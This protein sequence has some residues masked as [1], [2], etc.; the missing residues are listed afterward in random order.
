MQ[1]SYAH[2]K[3]KLLQSRYNDREAPG[4]LKKMAEGVV[5]LGAA[6][7]PRPAVECSRLP[8]KAGAGKRDSLVFSGGR[9]HENIVFAF[10][11]V[12]LQLNEFRE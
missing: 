1:H 12:G 8:L 5:E 6:G 10:A 4:R 3:S 9:I 7:D 2:A 11:D